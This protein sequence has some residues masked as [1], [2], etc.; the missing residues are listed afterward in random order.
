MAEQM[1]NPGDKVIKRN[2]RIAANYGHV[3][4]VE[5]RQRES[6]LHIAVYFQRQ[7]WIKPENL[8]LFST[9]KAQQNVKVKSLKNYWV[10][11]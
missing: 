5:A 6:G 2:E 4:D 7:V 8:M 11:S 1:F 10:Q 3:M 9:W